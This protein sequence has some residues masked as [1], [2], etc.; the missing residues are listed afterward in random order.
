MRN[1]T[2]HLQD[3]QWTQ[4]VY[5]EPCK[6]K[7]FIG[8]RHICQGVK[9]HAGDHWSYSDRGD[10]LNSMPDGGC[11]S[12][13]PDHENYVHPLDK[14]KELPFNYAVTTVVTDE[15]LISRLNRNEFGEG[16]TIDRPC[17]QAEIDKLE[18]MG[19]LEPKMVFS[20]QYKYNDQGF[21]LLVIVIGLIVF[22]VLS[23]VFI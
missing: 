23:I 20:N 18:K 4:T 8:S 9:G 19:R 21:K 3:G 11:A 10:Y 7:T 15:A 6:E 1:I 17:T 2:Y 16:E 5:P 12:T 22:G 13:P 14:Q